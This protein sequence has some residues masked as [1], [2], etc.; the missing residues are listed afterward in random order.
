MK[1][2][3][4]FGCS[5][6]TALMALTSALVFQ[7]LDSNGQ[8]VTLTNRNSSAS[9]DLNS[10]AGMYSWKV[11]GQ[12]QL[13]Q[14][15]FWYRVGGLGVNNPDRPVNTLSAASATQLLPNY[16]ISTYAN[17]QLSVQ[18]SYMLTGQ[19][20]GSGGAD[21]QE[22][23][24]IE[25]LS[26][27][28]LDLH[29]FQYSDFDLAGT[30]GGDTVNLNRDLASGR[31]T[32]ATQ[33]KDTITLTETIAQTGVIP[34]ANRGEVATF[35]ST[36]NQLATSYDLNNSVGPVTGD[37][38]WALQWDLTLADGAVFTI[39]KDKLLTGVVIPE[40]SSLA[41]VSLGLLGYALR[42]RS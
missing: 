24:Q 39:S 42:R 18:I 11:D 8:L 6:I 28:P 19:R 7:T 15:W 4:M 23:I 25:N 30:V 36:L 1:C 2:F 17:S 27:A 21:L 40:P 37:A 33:S 13:A 10:A 26:G 32:G 38:T 5:R 3:K 14:Q 12:N 20:A 9:V 41:L 35:P 22:T 29:F 34:W 16:L 31:F